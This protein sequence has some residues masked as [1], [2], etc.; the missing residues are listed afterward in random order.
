MS[1]PLLYQTLS[2]GI[3]PTSLLSDICLS[4]GCCLM[5]S[6]PR[7]RKAFLLCHAALSVNNGKGLPCFRKET[8]LFKNNSSQSIYRHTP[9]KCDHR[10][11][12][13]N[14]IYILL[15]RAIQGLLYLTPVE[16]TVQSTAAFFFFKHCCIHQNHSCLLSWLSYSLQIRK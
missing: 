5:L 7:Q 12:L 10:L 9:H 3:C 1:L 13:L 15:I 11:A 14:R 6:L 4:T 2:Q 16:K 8:L